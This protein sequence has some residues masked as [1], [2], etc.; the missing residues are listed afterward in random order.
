MKTGTFCDDATMPKGK[1]KTQ[2]LLAKRAG[3]RAKRASLRA[4]R[5]KEKEIK[6]KQAELKNKQQGNSTAAS[7]EVVGEKSPS[8]GKKSISASNNTNTD[9]ANA[10]A[11]KKVEEKSSDLKKVVLNPPRKKRALSLGTAS[12]QNEPLAKRKKPPVAAKRKDA[13]QG[14]RKE[15]SGGGAGVSTSDPAI[16]LPKPDVAYPIVLAGDFHRNTVAVVKYDFKPASFAET[17]VMSTHS[18]GRVTALHDGTLS[19]LIAF[20]FEG[21]SSAANEGE[22]VLAFDGN[23]FV[24]H[25]APAIVSLKSAGTRTKTKQEEKDNS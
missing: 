17:G 1:S 4:K 8:E 13:A 22:Y 18:D 16:L 11:E 2:S 20:E 24:V 19:S 6:K 23:T 10:L 12:A 25:R 7:S 15:K 14:N 9:D 21:T 5:A 3:L